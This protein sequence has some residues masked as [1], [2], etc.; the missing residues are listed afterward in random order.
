MAEDRNWEK[1]VLGEAVDKW[2]TSSG[3][4]EDRNTLAEGVSGVGAAWRPTIATGGRW[5]APRRR[6]GFPCSGPVRCSVP[7]CSPPTSMDCEDAALRARAVAARHQVVS[8][9]AFTGRRFGSCLE[10]VSH[11]VVS[12]TDAR[13]LGG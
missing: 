8:P 1:A 5:R 9:A 6:G 3:A 10:Y 12:V 13:F 2:R 11:A 7:S 4:T